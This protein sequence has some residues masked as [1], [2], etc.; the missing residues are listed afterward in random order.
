MADV[1]GMVD[2]IGRY[3]MN[4]H[5]RRFQ[6]R[7]RQTLDRGGRGAR[8]DPRG[9]GG[10]HLGRAKQRAVVTAGPR[11][12]RQ[13]LKRILEA[14]LLAGVYF[15]AAKFGLRLAFLHPS[16]TPVWPPTGIAIAALL[17]LGARAWPGIFIGAL[18]ANITTEG[19]VWTSLGIAA[20]NTLEAVAAAALVNRYAG[21]RRAFDRLE[22]I[23]RFAAAAALASTMISATVGV[24]ALALGGFAP[25]AQYGPIWLT[26][27]LGDACG[28]LVVTPLVLLWNAQPRLGWT[29]RGTAER[30]VFLACL[31][32]V[33]LAVFGSRFPFGFAIVPFLIWAAFRF[34]A[35]DAATVVAL[36]SAVAIVGTLHQLGPFATS[37]TQ[38]NVSLLYLSLFM[39]MMAMIALT[40]ARIVE[41]RAT[42]ADELRRQVLAEEDARRIAE[43]AVEQ[44][45]RLAAVTALLSEA[46]TPRDV[47]AVIVTQAVEALGAR[48]AAV[49][50]LAE[51]E[52]H[53]D[54]IHA[55]GYPEDVVQRWHRFLPGQFGGIAEC[56]RT[57]RIVSLETEADL[58]REY[59]EREVLPAAVRAGARAAVPLVTRGSAVGVLY[60][61]FGAYRR[62]GDDE[63]TFMRA[64]GQQCAQAV[65]RARLYEREHHV[66]ETFQRA[67]LPIAIPHLPGVAIHTVYQPG[68]HESNVGGDW[69]DVFRLPSGKLVVS[70]GD[71]AGRGLA[72]AVVMGELRQTIRTAALDHDDPAAVL[73]HASHALA[74]AHGR[75]AMATAIVAIFD[76]VLSALSYATAGHPAPVLALPGGEPAALPAAGVPLGFLAAP[77]APSWT[78]TLPAG[79]LLV[80][81]TDGLIEHE[82]DVVAGQD[83]LIRAARR[84]LAGP[85]GDPARAILREVLGNRRSGDDIAIITLAIDPAPL[86][87]FDLTLPADPASAV[88][89]RQ[90]VR[91][92]AR[93]AGLDEARTT[94]LAIAV[95]EAVNNTIE[96]AYPAAGGTMHVE[97]VRDAEALRVSVIDT[98]AWRPPHTSGG[99]GHGLQ[100]I[101]RLGDTV[102]IRQTP[103]GT[104]VT[105]A[106]RLPR[107]DPAPEPARQTAAPP[108]PAS[109]PAAQPPPSPRPRG[110]AQSGRE[111]ADAAGG[112]V[113]AIQSAADT[114]RGPAGARVVRL[115]GMLVVEAFGDLDATCLDAVGRTLDE[116]AREEAAIV[117]VSLEQAGYIDSLTIRQLF[118][119][120][121]DLATRRRSLALIV[122]PGSA[123]ERIVDV[124]GLTGEFRVYASMKD[125]REAIKE[126]R[127]YG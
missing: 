71:V 98:G 2:L 63:I 108:A 110:P 81:Y 33:S 94:A 70:I 21:G 115:D 57:G 52:V 75:E 28:A 61:N 54:L 26:W 89:I 20:G 55:V 32:A 107:R 24:T 113:V 114:H 102:E 18:A 50:L 51:D 42:A 95:G 5:G 25:W 64:L 3:S 17:L 62:F 49:S 111:T 60:M 118:A 59:P 121:R 79:A 74:L 35:R 14:A 30:L 83:A 120:G 65:E 34:G 66:A 90:S 91:R 37:I 67:L 23:A 39:A 4:R 15:L 82:R 96:H 117:V 103:A 29:A 126:V 43:R 38:P 10:T 86:D 112:G 127:H 72:A 27:W 92:L 87:R 104:T 53:L 106:M 93:V 85:S 48:A 45:T 116:A 19:T 8:P 99:G 101:K 125:A 56:L 88:L 44:A 69:Y 122:P 109:E 9:A 68:A 11:V 22:N 77:R 105:I 76:P 73:E 31:L 40:V 7:P 123:L 58:A 84:E 12:D 16:A 47:A 1:P 36:V 6:D 100:L 97:G 78:V 119:F 46:V 41:E 13:L 80:L 124:A